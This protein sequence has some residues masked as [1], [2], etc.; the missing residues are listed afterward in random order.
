MNQAGPLSDDGRDVVPGLDVVD[1]GGLAV[2]AL[3]R[4]EGRT[5]ARASGEA[6]ERGDQRRLFAA[7]E[8][9]GALDQLDIEVEAAAEDVV[10]E[11]A[12]LARLVDGAFEAVH[13]ERILGANV[14]DAL[15]GAGARSRR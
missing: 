6:F 3:L 2:Q 10:A 5:R 15:G 8:R 13:G 11:H 14:D 4:G 7:D 9:A 1:V 12:V